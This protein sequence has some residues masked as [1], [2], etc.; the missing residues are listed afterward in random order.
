MPTLKL[1]KR[2]PGKDVIAAVYR[3]A[4]ES[5]G[6]IH[7]NYGNGHHVS[8]NLS[9]RGGFG[10]G[11]TSLEV[12]LK[13]RWFGNVLNDRSRYGALDATGSVINGQ[14]GRAVDLERHEGA[15]AIY[16]QFS[17]ELKAALVD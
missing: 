1:G 9:A 15:R 16:D 13:S 2:F 3:A 8:W 17:R 4:G 10:Q 12:T 7:P 11:D 6:R 14:W 5:G